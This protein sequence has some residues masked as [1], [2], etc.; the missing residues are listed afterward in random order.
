MLALDVVTGTMK[1]RIVFSAEIA[2]LQMV[3]HVTR[4]RF[5]SARKDDGASTLE[6]AIISA[7]LVAA[8]ALIAG[9]ILAKVGEKSGDISG[10]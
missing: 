4:G 9:V 10:Y 2:Y 7:I 1:G 8:A 6:L 3:L 5:D